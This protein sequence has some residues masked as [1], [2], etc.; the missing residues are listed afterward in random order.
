[1][2]QYKELYPSSLVIGEGLIQAISNIPDIPWSNLSDDE[3]R[4]LEQ[5]YSIRS[6]FK[7]II[8]SFESLDAESRA[9]VI[10]G[11]FKQKWTRLWNIFSL[12]YNPLDAYKV[13]ESGN[14]TLNVN[15]TQVDIYGR[16][17]L[18][19]GTDTGTVATEGSDTEN[20][21][22]SVY[23]FNSPI[24][25]PSDNSTKDNIAKSTETRNLSTSKSTT[26]SGQ[27]E[28]T[29]SGS[30]TEEYGYTK[31]GNIGY[32]SPQE[33]IRRDMELWS[34]PFFKTVFDDIDSLITISVY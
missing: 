28:T 14:K 24:A 34:S 32:T 25:L 3:K 7:I 12:E 20:S 33:L 23:G 21:L 19:G 18:E 10:A 13:T 17:V 2:I 4:N 26:N 6:G 15:R 27:D 1:M 31:T 9:K 30:D 11:Y 16:S 22:D 5:A 8:D 29:R